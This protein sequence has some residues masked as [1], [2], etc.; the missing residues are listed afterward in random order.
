MCHK[1]IKP[2]ARDDP[3]AD[4]MI[5]W[6]AFIEELRRLKP[7]FVVAAEPLDEAEHFYVCSHCS[8]AVDSRALADVLYHDRPGHL[9]ELRQ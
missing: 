5:E 3:G 7:G 1:P 9:P 2:A 6:D 8:Q 4:R